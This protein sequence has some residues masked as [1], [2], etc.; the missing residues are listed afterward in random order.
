MGEQNRREQANS[1]EELQ[2]NNGTVGSLSP[3]HLASVFAK[4]HKCLYSYSLA[5]KCTKNRSNPC[6]FDTER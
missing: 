5:L 6:E 1:R 2:I 4:T 3:V